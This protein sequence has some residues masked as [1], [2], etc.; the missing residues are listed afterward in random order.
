MG[1]LCVSTQRL[2]IVLTGYASGK[3]PLVWLYSQPQKC[4]STLTAEVKFKNPTIWITGGKVHGNYRY[5]DPIGLPSPTKGRQS[6]C[7]YLTSFAPA[8]SYI[9]EAHESLRFKITAA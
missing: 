9:T 4:P 7:A 2:T 5:R 1:V 3:R 6:F 8:F